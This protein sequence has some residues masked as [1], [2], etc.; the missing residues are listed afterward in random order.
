MKIAFLNEKYLHHSTGGAH[1]SVRLLAES[2][3]NKG[4]EISV[5]TTT[6]RPEQGITTETHG[7]VRVIHLPVANVYWPHEQRPAY[8]KPFWHAIDAYNPL[9]ASGVGHLLDAEKPDVLHTNILASFSPSV[10]SE[11]HRRGVP[12]VHTLRDHYLRCPSGAMFTAC[13]NCDR[14]CTV[15]TVLSAPKKFATRHVSAVVGISNYLLQTHLSHGYFKAS[16]MR[17]VIH[18]SYACDDSLPPREEA[19]SGLRIGYLGRLFETKGI[20]LLIDTVLRGTE[21]SAHLIIAGS[22]AGTYEARLRERCDASPSRIIFLGDVPPRTLFEQIDV[23][24][25][26]SLWHE[27]FGRVAIEANA[28]GIPVVASRRG[29]LPEIVEHAVTGFLFEPDHPDE[30]AHTLRDLTPER[31]LA[32]R[33]ACLLKAQQFLP[34]VIAGQYEMLYRQLVEST[35]ATTLQVEETFSTPLTVTACEF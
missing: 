17:T 34:T 1:Q 14:Q 16:R 4:H 19:S 22:G 23:L 3:V 2:L 20:E 15:C 26:P 31:C 11:A 13:G 5:W 21:S 7:G 29:G 35:R 33:E 9:M 18:N 32:M 27:P 6:Y 10:W 8:L 24:V 12:V 28:W 25:V 30:L